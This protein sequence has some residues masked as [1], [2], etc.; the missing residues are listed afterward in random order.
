MMNNNGVH[1]GLQTP[2]SSASSSTDNKPLVPNGTFA[3]SSSTNAL[4]VPASRH[5]TLTFDTPA[6]K[7][8]SRPRKDLDEVLTASRALQRKAAQRV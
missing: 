6:E 4:Q 7:E 3:A 8:A 1:S 2:N 5:E